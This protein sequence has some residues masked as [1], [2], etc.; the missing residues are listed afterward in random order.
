MTCWKNTV[1][2]NEFNMNQEWLN[3]VFIKKTRNTPSALAQSAGN[4]IELTIID[5]TRFYQIRS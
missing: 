4:W 2:H 1:L 5:L 3:E